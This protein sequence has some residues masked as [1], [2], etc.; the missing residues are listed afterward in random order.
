MNTKNFTYAYNSF[1]GENE[2]MYLRS[3]GT[4]YY[5]Y[6]VEEIK[7]Q[8]GPQ[9][10]VAV[11]G[12]TTIFALPTIKAFM[13]GLEVGNYYRVIYEGETF[14]D[15]GYTRHEYDIERISENEYQRYAQDNF[16][17]DKSY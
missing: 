17:D 3:E 12:M 5:V 10:L 7:G 14:F 8:Y 9:L 6:V 4:L 1:T 11:D 2:I 15:N 16:T 13:E